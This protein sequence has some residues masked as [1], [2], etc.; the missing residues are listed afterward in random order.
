MITPKQV[1]KL[2]SKPTKDMEEFQELYRVLALTIS[3]K[4]RPNDLSREALI[5]LKESLDK[6]QASIAMDSEES[7]Y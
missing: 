4:T 1:E 2:F 7:P 6:L 5:L 3:K